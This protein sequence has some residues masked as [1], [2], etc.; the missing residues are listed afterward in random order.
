MS[1]NVMLGD[2]FFPQ[3]FWQENELFLSRCIASYY[4]SCYCISD[5]FLV[6]VNDV[7]ILVFV[8]A[9]NHSFCFRCSISIMFTDN[10]ELINCSKQ[11]FLT[12]PIVSNIGFMLFIPV[13]SFN[14]LI[15]SFC[16]VTEF[17]FH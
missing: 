4:N 15:S 8:F 5:Y 6:V 12:I 10:T 3:N 7:Y 1:V 13:Q 16:C 17:P 2:D 11:P 14:A 9:Y